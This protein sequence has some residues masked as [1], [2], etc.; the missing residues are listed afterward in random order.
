MGQVIGQAIADER[1]ED[2][3]VEI[4]EHLHSDKGE[5]EPIAE[6]ISL[7]KEEHAEKEPDEGRAEEQEAAGVQVHT[8]KM[9]I[10][11]DLRDVI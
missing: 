9:Q 6:G 4:K 11:G 8:V 3:V 2:F 10:V 5:G 7:D 1:E